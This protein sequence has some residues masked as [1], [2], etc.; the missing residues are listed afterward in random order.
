MGAGASTKHRPR[1][2]KPKIIEPRCY[3][4]DRLGT[5]WF[6]FIKMQSMNILVQRR[7]KPRK[8]PRY[9][10]IASVEMDRTES[11]R[12]PMSLGFKLKPARWV[13]QGIFL[14]LRCDFFFFF[15]CLRA[16][17]WDGGI[18]ISRSKFPQNNEFGPMNPE[19]TARYPKTKPNSCQATD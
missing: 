3:P 9:T 14:R 8:Y 7:E 1:E 2:I 18:V 13:P 15:F 5:L 17:I 12:W 4:A 11:L 10:A 16:Q 19:Q 6:A